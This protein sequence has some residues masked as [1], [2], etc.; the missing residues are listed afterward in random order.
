MSTDHRLQFLA[1]VS[2]LAEKFAMSQPAPSRRLPDLVSVESLTAQVLSPAQL[3]A[4]AQ[5][6]EGVRMIGQIEQRINVLAVGHEL[7]VSLFLPQCGQL[8]AELEGRLFDSGVAAARLHN[9]AKAPA[10]RR[11]AA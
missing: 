4:I 1:A 5:I 10:G 9:G 2:A 11:A 8:W 7:P 6:Q 3:D